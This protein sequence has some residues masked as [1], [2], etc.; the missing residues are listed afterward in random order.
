MPG[1]GRVTE[2]NLFSWF[3]LYM[4]GRSYK[5]ISKETKSKLEYILYM[6]DHHDWYAKRQQHYENLMAKIE[7]KMTTAKIEGVSFLYDLLSVMTEMHKNDI[8]EFLSTKNPDAAA[9]V[10]LRIIDRY[11]KAVEAIS[12][13]TA[14]PDEWLKHQE[15]NAAS[16][17]TVN[18]N[19]ENATINKPVDEVLE[20]ESGQSIISKLAELKKQKESKKD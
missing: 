6:S 17:P 14:S 9:R 7:N 10:D 2:T 12:K 5:E 19:I 18:I 3:N 16:S 4:S 8:V 13:L 1:I 20:I 11:T 15:R